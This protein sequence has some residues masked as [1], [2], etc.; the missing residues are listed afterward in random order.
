MD[1]KY[2]AE[3]YPVLR[4]ASLFFV[5][6]GLKSTEWVSGYGPTTSPENKFRMINGS[7]VAVSAGSTMDN[8]LIRELL[9]IRWRLL[10]SGI[11]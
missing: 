10:R 7:V 5:D 8:Q 9:E 4:V 1:K 11:G 2:L 6:S 3:V